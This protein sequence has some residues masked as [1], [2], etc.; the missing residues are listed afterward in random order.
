MIAHAITILRVISPLAPH[1]TFRRDRR[2]QEHPVAEV[3]EM[4]PE[5]IFKAVAW[6]RENKF[7]DFIKNWFAENYLGKPEPLGR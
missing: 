5:T 1:F 6:G 3:R 4:F 2:T 7:T